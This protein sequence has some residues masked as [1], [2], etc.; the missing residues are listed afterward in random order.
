MA[1]QVEAPREV[2]DAPVKKPKRKQVLHDETPSQVTDHAFEPRGEWYTLCKYCRLSEAAH[3]ETTLTGREHI[4]YYSDD[5]DD[6]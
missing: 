6:Q 5:N 3:Q 2:K 4:H 1:E